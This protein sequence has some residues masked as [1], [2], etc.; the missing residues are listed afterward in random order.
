MVL[1]SPEKVSFLR[2]PRGL[3]P[4]LPLRLEAELNQPQQRHDDALHLKRPQDRPSR[5]REI[6][7]GCLKTLQRNELGHLYICTTLKDGSR[8]GG[9]QKQ[10]Q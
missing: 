3:V 5:N 7:H 9:L 2:V 10:D 1:L 6:G 4:P 8:L